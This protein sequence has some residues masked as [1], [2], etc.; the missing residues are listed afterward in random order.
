M[1]AR[2]EIDSNKCKINGIYTHAPLLCSEDREDSTSDKEKKTKRVVRRKK[3][4]AAFFERPLLTSF[5]LTTSSSRHSI[6]S[7]QKPTRHTSAW[8]TFLLP[9]LPKI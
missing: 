5:I 7:L 4:D 3:N 1:G 9:F 8:D 6:S 2:D